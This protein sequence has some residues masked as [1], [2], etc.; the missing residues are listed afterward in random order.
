MKLGICLPVNPDAVRILSAL[1]IN[2]TKLIQ[3]F[4]RKSRKMLLQ[5]ASLQDKT[6]IQD[7]GHIIPAKAYHLIPESWEIAQDA[8]IT[9][10][11]EGFSHR[12][13]TTTEFLYKLLFVEDLVW[14]IFIRK[15]SIQYG[16]IY[17][18][19][20]AFL[21]SYTFPHFYLLLS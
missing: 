12:G 7:L 15:N 17:D 11:H 19:L 4:L 21:R 10:C 8:V 3:L 13:F 5:I 14:L 6:K 1:Y 20:Q 18:I 9:Q 2:S 16:L